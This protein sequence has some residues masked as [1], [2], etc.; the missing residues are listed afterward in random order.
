MA[1]VPGGTVRLQIEHLRRECGCYP[2][3]GTPPLQW[4]RFV[5]GN[6]FTQPLKHDYTVEL[7]PF[8]IDEAAVTNAQYAEFLRANGYAP[9]D[10]QNF[11]KHWVDGKPAPGQEDWPVVNVDLDDA[12]A[13][14]RWA[15]KR[16]PTEPEWHLA[17]QGTDGRLW[18]SG[19]EFDA[20]RVNQTGQPLPVRALPAGRSPY[21]C[22]QMAGN[23]YELTESLRDD[24]HTRFLIVRGGSYFQAPGSIWYFDGGPRPCNH[25]AKL[26]LMSPSLDRSPTIGFRCVK[27]VE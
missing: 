5:W 10:A 13:Y 11:L 15:G 8:A 24:G 14:A 1:L 4:E 2:D 12:H 7:R 6:D 22:Y 9:R 23:V 16:L 3:P 26:L 20:A 19:N 21:G 18:P 27:D 17:A 25:H